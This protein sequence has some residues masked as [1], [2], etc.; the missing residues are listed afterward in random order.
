MKYIVTVRGSKRLDAFGTLQVP[1]DLLE[2]NP[3]VDGI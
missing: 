1:T 3:F 2:T